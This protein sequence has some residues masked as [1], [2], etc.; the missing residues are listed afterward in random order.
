MLFS[1]DGNLRY[2]TDTLFLSNDFTSLIKKATPYLIKFS[3]ISN[4]N[5]A[6]L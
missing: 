1:T 6:V 2:K 5:T 4:K 3:G